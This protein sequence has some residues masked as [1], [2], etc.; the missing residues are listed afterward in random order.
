MHDCIADE[1]RYIDIPL[2]KESP[3]ITSGRYLWSRV[4]ISTKSTS[5]CSQTGILGF[6][7]VGTFM[8][9]NDK[10]GGGGSTDHMIFLCISDTPYLYPNP[11]ISYS[12]SFRT[13][14]FCTQFESVHTRTVG[15]FVPLPIKKR[16]MIILR[17]MINDQ[18]GQWLCCRT[19][20]VRLNEN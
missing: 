7:N 11:V 17:S 16:S 3:D 6:K 1:I 10:A 2:P 19:Q 14:S 8:M 9:M 12:L 18:S 20:N 5:A 15:R 4:D 13:Q